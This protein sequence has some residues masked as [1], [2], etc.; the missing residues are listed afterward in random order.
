LEGNPEHSVK[1]DVTQFDY[2]EIGVLFL[3]EGSNVYSEQAAHRRQSSTTGNPTVGNILDLI[4]TADENNVKLD[5]YKLS[6]TGQGCAYWTYKF[7]ER[8]EEVGYIEHG[9]A[10]AV[11]EE[12]QWY[13]D[14]SEAKYKLGLQ[15]RQGVF[16]Y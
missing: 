5:C 6:P 16:M 2:S 3:S 8:I 9:E 15:N 13:W 12:I 1:I 4:F 14:R 10:A 7:M 11:F